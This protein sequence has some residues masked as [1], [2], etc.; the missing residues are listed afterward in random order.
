M[1]I[2]LSASWTQPADGV[3]RIQIAGYTAVIEESSTTNLVGEIVP[4]YEYTI[5]R[6]HFEIVATGLRTCAVAAEITVEETIAEHAQS[7]SA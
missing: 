5:L 3:K 7:L 4:A 1:Q 2:T 6:D